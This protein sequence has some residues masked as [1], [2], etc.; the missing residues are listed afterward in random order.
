M[1]NLSK[2]LI[3]AALVVGACTAAA[4]AQF[5][6]NADQEYGDQLWNSLM[7]ADLVGENAIMA[8]PYEG[9]SPHGQILVTLEQNLE[10]QGE[11]GS[12]IVK[13]NYAGDGISRDAVSNSPQ[14]YLNSITV[15]FQREG[16]DPENNDWFWAKYFPD[17]SY[18]TAPNGTSLVGRPTGC[19]TCHQQEEDMVF[20]ND[21]Y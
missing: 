19:I 17:G 13:R 16:F 4:Q 11:T 12:V 10:V 5:G 8:R 1:K 15:M 7:D 2:Y 21:R 9:T 18:D 6:T 20:L 14:E 3:P